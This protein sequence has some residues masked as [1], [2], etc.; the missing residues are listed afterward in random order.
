MTDHFAPAADR[1]KIPISKMLE[2]FLPSHGSILELASG[3]GQHVHFFAKKFSTL[4]WQPSDM[5]SCHFEHI[6]TLRERQQLANCKEPIILDTREPNWPTLRCDAIYCA[7][8]IHISPWTSTEGLF[9]HS[10]KL[11][12]TKQPLILYGPFLFADKPTA[13]SNIQFDQSLKQR[14]PLWGLRS[15]EKLEKVAE[16]F[17]FRCQ[18][19]VEMPANNHSLVFEKI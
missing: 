11:L 2:S 16:K 18:D 3:T 4:D 12:E 7:N 9:Q 8:M 15:F 1:N 13:A 10:T 6:N 19:I 17:Q 5:D 14:N